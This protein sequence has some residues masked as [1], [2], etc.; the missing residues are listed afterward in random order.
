[1][2]TTLDVSLD[3]LTIDASIKTAKADNRIDGSMTTRCIRE[4][5]R[6]YTL[7]TLIAEAGATE[8]R[9]AEFIEAV[10]TVTWT[11]GLLVSTS[12]DEA[13][14]NYSPG[15]VWLA[16]TATVDPHADMRAGMTKLHAL[17]T[18]AVHSWYIIPADG[19]THARQMILGSTA[20]IIGSSVP[21]TIRSPYDAT[22]IVSTL[23]SAVCIV[24]AACDRTEKNHA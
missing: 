5:M 17:T 9:V 7:A 8:Q 24:D 21:R 11:L 16:Q 13:G 12:I 20:T 19:E 10:Q 14:Q 1:M 18:L 4:T 23:D 6:D 15:R 22:N 3:T 2:T